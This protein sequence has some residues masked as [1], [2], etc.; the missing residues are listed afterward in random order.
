MKC[1]GDTLAFRGKCAIFLDVIR[2]ELREN[3]NMD[4]LTGLIK[5]LVTD[6]GTGIW[7]GKNALG[8]LTQ[9]QVYLAELKQFFWRVE[10][11]NVF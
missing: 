9:L 2:K 11:L 5:N 8:T 7:V 10:L 3:I 6:I 4:R 1:P